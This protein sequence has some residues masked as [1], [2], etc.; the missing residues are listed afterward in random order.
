ML[1][2]DIAAAEDDSL[3]KDGRKKPSVTTSTITLPND[4][5]ELLRNVA[6]RR[7]TVGR[8][9]VSNVIRDLVRSNESK[10]RGELKQG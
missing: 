4:L 9:S 8:P 2:T 7:R 10:F 6:W 5:W 3:R 1:I